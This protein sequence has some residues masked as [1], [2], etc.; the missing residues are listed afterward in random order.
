ML[1]KLSPSYTIYKLLQLNESKK[2][3]ESC[4]YNESYKVN[5][6]SDVKLKDILMHFGYSD[7]D[8][9]PCKTN[10]D[11][12]YISECMCCDMGPPLQ[13]AQKTIS[14]SPANN[15]TP[16]E[17]SSTLTDCSNESGLDCLN[18]EI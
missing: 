11:L 18:I 10:P 15:I 7:P 4:K 5:E 1:N 2:L 17:D 8:K 3:N 9:S 13:Q 16:D 6:S 14:N 12:F